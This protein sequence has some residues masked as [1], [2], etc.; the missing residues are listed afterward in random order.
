MFRMLLCVFL[1]CGGSGTPDVLSVSQEEAMVGSRSDVHIA[2]LAE[3]MAKGATVVDVR[4]KAEF[5]RGH[6]PGA[7]HQPLGSWTAADPFFAD[8][9]RSQPV[10]MICQSGARSAAA[11]DQLAAAGYHAVNVLGGTGAWMAAGREVTR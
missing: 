10:Y 11:A 7:N 3:A 9:D 2:G 5:A 8:L 6:V 4:T 1:G